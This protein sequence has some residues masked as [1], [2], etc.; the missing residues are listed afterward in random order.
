MKGGDSIKGS[1]SID[2]IRLK[3]R[4]PAD[5]I[6]P[7]MQSLMNMPDVEY[8]QRKRISEYR[9]NWT[10]SVNLIEAD[11][12][13]QKYSFYI[14]YQHNTERPGLNYN[15]V[16][17]FNPNKCPMDGVLKQIIDNYFIG[18]KVQVVSADV[19]IDFPVNIRNIVFDRKRK[20]MYKYFESP[21]DGISHYFG[22]GGP[23]QV[24]VYNKTAEANLKYDLTRY[25]VRIGVDSLVSNINSLQV[26]IELPEVYILSDQITMDMQKD[27][28][29]MAII[30]AVCNG[31]PIHELSRDYRQKIKPLNVN[32]RFEIEELQIERTI[33]DYVKNLF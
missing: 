23:G 30:Y 1:Y 28:T 19:A 29:L 25:E 11:G 27:K 17:E 31:Y 9:H 24:K 16:I 26:K 10:Y 15:F 13:P 20:R 22:N 3:T 8:W 21:G 14:A 5:L 6:Q 18:A 33:K 32:E 2:M 7:F 12:T 4:I